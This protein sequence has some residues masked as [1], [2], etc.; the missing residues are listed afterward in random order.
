MRRNLDVA[1]MQQGCQED[2]GLVS[3][4]SLVQGFAGPI[5]SPGKPLRADFPR[6][7]SAR[8]HNIAKG[9]NGITAQG[10]PQKGLLTP[11][12]D[13]RVDHA[14]GR[15]NG[16]DYGRRQTDRPGDRRRPGR[17]RL[18]RRHPCQPVY[19]RSGGARVADRRGR[20]PGD[21]AS[22]RSCRSRSGRRPDRSGGSGD[23]G[24]DL[25]AGQ[26]GFRVR[27]RHRARPGL[28]RLGPAFRH[29]RQG[30]GAA[31]AAACPRPA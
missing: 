5:L 2:D 8:R 18:F 28:A 24:A 4:A 21:G 12:R 13:E 1:F 9:H 10:L 20:R 14:R 23:A 22:R 17:A 15:W 19:R 26:F 16:F 27:R 11:F 7:V 6:F 25:A 30:A 3:P 29:S 31:V